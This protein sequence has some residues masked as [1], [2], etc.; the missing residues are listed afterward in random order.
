M[1]EE[2][3]TTKMLKKYYE[4]QDEYEKKYGNKTVVLMQVGAFYEVYGI[5][6]V[7][8][9]EV[10]NS[11]IL[12]ISKLCNLA[13]S[14]KNKD[15]ETTYRNIGIGFRDYS[16]E[17]YL[18][19]LLCDG[20]IVPVYNQDSPSK[21]T[22]RSLFKIFTPGSTILNNDIQ[23]TNNVMCA[24]LEK[25]DATLLQPKQSVYIGISVLDNHSGKCYL[26]E[27]SIVPFSHNPSSYEELERFY[28]VYKPNEFYF[29]SKNFTEREVDSIIQW[30]NIL[31]NLHKISFSE[32]SHFME[33]AKKCEKQLYQK[34]IFQ[35]YYKNYID[36]KDFCES[37]LLHYFEYAKQSFCFLLD[38]LTTFNRDILEK[39][40]EPKIFRDC[41]QMLLGNHSLKQL[42]ILPDA[43]YHGKLA[44]VMD[45]I[46]SHSHT[47]MGKRELKNIL[48]NPIYDNKT[49]EEKYNHVEYINENS[50]DFLGISKNLGKIID[51]EK[52]FRKMMICKFTPGQLRSLYQSMLQ[53]LNI[54]ES[55]ENHYEYL[56]ILEESNQDL[57]KNTT[58]LKEK[59][60]KTVNIQL[61]NGNT[62][63][64]NIFNRGVYPSVD[65]IVDTL[66]ESES[67]LE[68]I[69]VFLDDCVCKE[70]RKKNKNPFVTFHTT[71]KNGIYIQC[72]KRRTKLLQECF[73]KYKNKVITLTYQ[74]NNKKKKFEFDVSTL[75]FLSATS[76]NQKIEN[77]VIRKLSNNV[78]LYKNKVLDE[79]NQ[80][81]DLFIKSLKENNNEF[82]TIINFVIS[83]DVTLT[84]AKLSKKYNYVKPIIVEH[85]KSFVDAKDMRHL[86]IEQFDNDEIYVCNDICLGKEL[87]GI[88]LFGTNAVGKSSFIKSLGICVVLAQSG[89]YVPCSSFVYKPYQSIFTR[90]LGND[91]IFKGLS[92]FQVEMVE[93]NSILKHSTENS[94]ILGDEL[95]SGTEMI[96]AISIFVSGLLELERKQNCFIFA[97]H[98]HEITKMPEIKAME[99]MKL[100]HMK[101][102]YNAEKDCLEYERKI[103]DG[104]GNSNYGLEVCRS[105]Q[106]PQHF[107][108]QAYSIRERLDPVSKKLSNHKKSSYN[109]KKLKGKCEMCH[110]EGQEVHHLQPQMDANEDGFIHN[111]HKNHVAN[112][113][114]VCKTCHAKF[115]K[116][117]TKLRRKKTTKGYVLESQ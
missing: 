62:I 57:K 30:C 113:M 18:D 108:D 23:I 92:T 104:P 54:Y 10:H 12:E 41:N 27:Y 33:N 60:E 106:M 116:Q 20:W 53:V 55:L 115:T 4:L 79:V 103:Q 24:W 107:L 102:V 89:F 22:T 47:I 95:C 58:I 21:N 5:L 15:S 101:V 8:S 83:L 93:L 111:F 35:M 105:L 73:K 2:V 3:A 69:R 31:C 100:K 91:N 109:P 29:I 94:L 43:S 16:L 37:N 52:Y 98:F 1:D 96:S 84:K 48:L 34:E 51:I 67:K 9:Q 36:Y 70:E 112:L 49:L 114:N 13:I 61:C 71:E 50:S 87:N 40:H 17:K 44:S 78:T 74:V 66:E 19:I 64:K 82:Q 59:I 76:T 63:D 46:I 99:K 72:T 42:N 11:P 77:D 97:T 65:K 14:H 25:K 28:S 110:A 39:I 38:T 32:P 6:H 81:F 86:L 117:N 68:C 56:H 7:V 26:H 85:E 80:Y 90:I 75:Q 88:C 45:F